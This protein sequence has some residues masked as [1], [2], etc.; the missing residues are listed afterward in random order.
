MRALFKPSAAP[1]LEM[2]ECAEPTPGPN[3]VKIRVEKTGICGTDL[4]IESWDAW[5]AS[6]VN[7][8]LII[9][10]EFSG[11]IVEL[12][13]DVTTLEVGRKLFPRVL[14][15]LLHT[16]GDTATVFVDL[17]NHDFD[18]FAECHNLAWIDVLVGPVHFGDV[19]QTFDTCFDFNERT[20]VGEVCNLAEQTCVLW[21][22]TCET[23]PWI[24]AELF[25]A[26]GNTALFLI[27]LEDFCFDFLTD[28]QDF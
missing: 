22:A 17:E 21:V 26:Q 6:A 13:T 2:I 10:H 14:T 12:G 15:A 7:A 8:P 19:N 27:E 24:F 16:Q 4:H 20:V 18:F 5:A 9:G 1:G 3:D 23:H 25:N 28:G 11:R